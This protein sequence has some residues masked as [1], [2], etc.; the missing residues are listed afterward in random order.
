MKEAMFYDKLERL[1]VQCKLCPHKCVI[2]PGKRGVCKVREND[3]GVLNSMVYGL[4]CTT[5]VDPIEKK[6]LYHFMPGSKTYSIATAG[7]NFH[8]K[9][10]Q[11]WEISQRSELEVPSKKMSPEEVVSKAEQSG[12]GSIAYT[13]VEPSIFYEY[14]LDCAKLAHKAGLKN[15]M[16]TNGYL[17]P[18]P[19]KKLFK[20]MDAI[21]VDVKG[22]TEEFYRE[23]CGGKLKPV[24]DTIKLAKKMGVWV[25]VTMLIVPGLNDGV[26]EIRKMCEWLLKEVG[27][28]VPLH[29][30][31]FFPMYK[32]THISPTPIQTLASAEYI[33]HEV[34]LK[35]VYVGNVN[36]R[37]GV[38]TL[39]PKCGAVVVKRNS[40][41][42]VEKNS[43]V[44]GKCKKCKAKV[45]GVW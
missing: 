16:V 5:A 42:V 28:S 30:S 26:D 9:W 3:G 20:Y 7:C 24:L 18:T 38:S 17:N 8:C 36:V 13:Y 19:E 45:E 2:L 39:C 29:F 4:P 34:G 11:N 22:F 15:V 23:Y 37:K 12:S 14:M 40:Y 43:L 1:K 6:P 31:R 25:E 21:N 27:P 35:N 32:M 44:G 41:Y 33:A 10:C